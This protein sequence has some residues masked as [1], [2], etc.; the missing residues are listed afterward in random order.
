MAAKVGKKKG[1]KGLII[2]LVLLIVFIAVGAV[3][4][5][6]MA[7]KI[8]IPGISPKKKVT[9]PADNKSKTK[10]KLPTKPKEP[11]VA[12][13]T[14]VVKTFDKQGA[15]KLAEVWNEIPTEKLV[16]VIDKWTPNDLALVMNEMDSTKAADVLGTLEPKRASQVSLELKRIASQVTDDQ[17]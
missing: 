1:K 4:G 8:N 15:Q 9:P 12:D 10:P 14:P 6:A 11:V 2:G 13:E 5:L 3:F 7:G 17:L 16:K